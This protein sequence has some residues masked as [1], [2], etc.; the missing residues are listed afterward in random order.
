MKSIDVSADDNLEFLDIIKDILENKEF[1]KLS[2]YEHHNSNRL[3][4]SLNVSYR[5]YKISKKLNFDYEKVTRAALLHDFFLI[6]NY[7]ITK[8]N[9]LK[10]LFNHPKYA[11]DN[12]LRYFDLSDM[13]KNIIVTHMFPLGRYLPR[14]KESLLVDFVDDYVAIR[15][16]YYS[17]K[18]E[19]SAALSFLLVFTFN[20]IFK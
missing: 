3:Q 4:H 20:F 7:S 19:L 16:A 1:Q 2:N 9:R 18:S 17:K 15:E 14:Y 13:E 12:S 11:L 6:D 8:Y 10:T 5:S